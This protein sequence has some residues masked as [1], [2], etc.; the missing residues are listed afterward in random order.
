MRAPFLCLLALCGSSACA[1]HIVSILELNQENNSVRSFSRDGRFVLFTEYRVDM[2]TGVASKLP[3][4]P[5]AEFTGYE[6]MSGNA[7][8]QIGQFSPDMF[9]PTTGFMRRN[10]VFAEMTGIG[11]PFAWAYDCSHDGRVR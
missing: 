8:V 3:R 5:G 1:S 6:A 4:F 9:T 7:Q 2:A 11:G 10:G